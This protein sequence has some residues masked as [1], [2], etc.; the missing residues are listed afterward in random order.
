MAI[1]YFFKNE[2]VARKAVSDCMNLGYWAYTFKSGV[3]AGACV[4]VECSPLAE[5]LIESRFSDD[6]V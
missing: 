4:G 5:G 2:V 1:R 3:P 6:L